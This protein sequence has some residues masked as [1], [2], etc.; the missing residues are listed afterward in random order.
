MEWKDV[1]KDISIKMT[2]KEFEHISETLRPKLHNIAL[3]F[4]RVS[5]VSIEADDI[6]LE[7][8]V[9]LWQFTCRE[10][11]IK[12]IEALS[13]KIAKNICVAHYRKRRPQLQP[14]AGD[15]Y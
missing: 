5:D 8:L 1:Y 12:N 13:V 15:D 10:P 7:T 9:A 11:N 6:I 14:L 2:L 4:L 3:K